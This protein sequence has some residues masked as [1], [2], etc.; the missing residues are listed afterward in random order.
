M[1]VKSTNDR[2]RVM[3]EDLSVKIAHCVAVYRIN[4]EGVH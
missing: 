3:D 2:K 1:T 4:K